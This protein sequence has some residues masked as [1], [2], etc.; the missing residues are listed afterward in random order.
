M[1]TLKD[2]DLIERQKFDE[3]FN[4][5]FNEDLRAKLIVGFT[6][7]VAWEAWQAS[8]AAIA[9]EID[10]PEP[11]DDHWKDGEEGAYALGYEDGKDKTSLAV[12]KALKSAGIKV[13]P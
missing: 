3:W 10:W 7:S 2:T 6:E 13:N 11:N 12:R 9:V 1:S 4:A 5:D 8:R